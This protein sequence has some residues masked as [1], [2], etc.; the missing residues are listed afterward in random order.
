D[1]N[2]SKGTIALQAGANSACWQAKPWAH[3][4][5]S[6]SIYNYT[7]PTFACPSGYWLKPAGSYYILDFEELYA[8]YPGGATLPYGY[9]VGAQMPSGQGSLN[10]I[11]PANKLSF[12]YTAG[13][14]ASANY[15]Q[16][17]GV[18]VSGMECVKPSNIECGKCGDGIFWGLFNICDKA[19]CLSISEG[20]CFFDGRGV[21]AHCY[22]KATVNFSL[23]D[24]VNKTII[25]GAK[26]SIKDF[27]SIT[28]AS[29]S[30]G[31]CSVELGLGGEYTASVTSVSGQNLTCLSPNCIKY[32]AVSSAPTNVELNPNKV[33]ECAD[34]DASS[35]FANGAKNYY[36]KGTVSE[37]LGNFTDKCSGKTLTEYSCLNNKAVVES[38]TCSTGCYDGACL[39]SQT[40]ETAKVVFE[41]KVV[42]E[43]GIFLQDPYNPG[44]NQ[45]AKGVVMMASGN[46]TYSCVTDYQGRCFAQLP[47]GDYTVYTDDLYFQ[48]K[49]EFGCPKAIKVLGNDTFVPLALQFKPTPSAADCQDTDFGN[50]TF[51]KG[52]VKLIKPGE[53]FPSTFI[54][55]CFSDGVNIVEGWCQY[56]L[57]GDF[58]KTQTFSCKYGCFDGA[59]KEGDRQEF[60]VLDKLSANPLG[61][62]L[63]KIFDINTPSQALGFDC[64]SKSD[65]ICSINLPP[66]TGFYV[67]A[68]KSG[69]FC[70]TDVCC[71]K[72]SAPSGNLLTLKMKPTAGTACASEGEKV[73]LNCVGQSENQCCSGLTAQSSDK[74]FAVCLK[75][76]DGICTAPENDHKCP[77]DCQVP[78]SDCR[79][80]DKFGNRSSCKTEEDCAAFG[81]YCALQEGKC[82]EKNPSEVQQATLVF[83]VY[84]ESAGQIN[85]K[86]IKGATIVSNSG[87]P[88]E[89]TCST[90]DNGS[91]KIAV[92]VGKRHTISVSAFGFEPSEPFLIDPSKAIDYPLTIYLKKALSDEEKLLT[93]KYKVIDSLA[94]RQ[95]ENSD[96]F[97]PLGAV[98]GD[99]LLADGSL[100][101]TCSSNSAGLCLLSMEIGQTY[102]V[103]FSK[104]GF[105]DYAVG[106]SPTLQD[107]NY[108]VNGIIEPARIVSLVKT[109]QPPKE[110]CS[111]TDGGKNYYVPGV[112][113]GIASVGGSA[114]WADSCLNNQTISEGFCRE[115]VAGVEPSYEVVKCP[116]GCQDNACK[117]EAQFFVTGNDGITKQALAGGAQVNLTLSADPNTVLVS[118]KTDGAGICKIPLVFGKEYIA[119]TQPAGFRRY[120]KQF[121]AQTLFS[122]TGN[123]P[124]GQIIY[125]EPMTQTAPDCSACG[126]WCTSN[127]CLSLGSNCVFDNFFVG[128]GSCHSKGDQKEAQ[129]EANAQRGGSLTQSVATGFDVA[130]DIPPGALDEE[131]KL[132]ITNITDE[133]GAPP[134]GKVLVGNIVYDIR[135]IS[136]STGKEVHNFKKPITISITLNDAFLSSFDRNSLTIRYFDERTGT[137]VELP[138]TI[139]G[140][141]LLAQTTHLSLFGLIGEVHAGD[142]TGTLICPSGATD[143]DGYDPFF[144]NITSRNGATAPDSCTG[145]TLRE[146]G[147]VAP[148]N[149]PNY[150][151]ATPVGTGGIV[152][153]G[154]YLMHFQ[155]F[156]CTQKCEGVYPNPGKCKGGGTTPATTKIECFESDNG[157]MP[158]SKGNIYSQYKTDSGQILDSLSSNDACSGDILTEWSCTSPPSSLFVIESK[159]VKTNDEQKILGWRT[160]YKCPGGVGCATDE[161]RCCDGQTDITAGT[162]GCKPVE[163]SICTD[164]EPASDPDCQFVS[165]DTSVA[166]YKWI[167]QSWHENQPCGGASSGKTCQNG[168]CKGASGG[169][170]GT[171][172]TGGDTGTVPVATGTVEAKPIDFGGI[173]IKPPSDLCSGIEKKLKEGSCAGK[174]STAM[175]NC[176]AAGSE[177]RK[178]TALENC[179][180]AD[181]E[182]NQCITHPEKALMQR[183]LAWLAW[184]AFTI[185]GVIILIGAFMVMTSSGDQNK[186][187]SGKKM[188]IWAAI[189][190]AVLLA[191]R[192]I[193]GILEAVLQVNII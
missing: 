75:C 45:V 169:T 80:I 93:Y 21:G 149:I 101:D 159:P 177:S 91:C 138:T 135:A 170:G 44:Q 168:E 39:K 19:E 57:S 74:N 114:I 151:D 160:T 54:D 152:G 22:N 48:C 183:A 137:M 136:L 167:V 18:I 76:G 165:C 141:T 90:I 180:M 193:I 5:G 87:A 27:D 110:K 31:A 184:V 119:W 153:S 16:D 132:V 164:P 118:C 179:L 104:E 189:G 25:S 52:A 121:V 42:D 100:V 56:G 84:D 47:L 66:A 147:C 34:S 108:I 107:R 62:A 32:F 64:S 59:C 154:I 43:N 60:K 171:G 157:F 33:I 127:E 14:Q 97:I 192:L 3:Y 166:P 128:L 88:N 10:A 120:S 20:S 29:N 53:Q 30:Q 111:D 122:Q 15:S 63:I 81:A 146:Y 99:A 174:D 2:Q 13:G 67:S 190:L 124:L 161:G 173:K 117:F 133:T 142:A 106:Y 126:T 17:L 51:V 187:R 7:S 86:P 158:N 186:V 95:A 181:A 78:C 49:A 182:Y 28:C 155:D 6:D 46:S 131:V 185:A 139:S 148:Q 71:Q 37:T 82:V 23:K 85:K 175:V 134:K 4:L 143:S 102:Q 113:S 144:P 1:C 92:D 123:T 176:L 65:G 115:S 145:N 103:K 156:D 11:F 36:Q 50:D 162:K 68:T 89:R 9:G 12:K 188:I 116:Y 55:Y 26:V 24:A 73:Y 69:Y 172:G 112:A 129:D 140:N 38:Y 94:S 105:S 191:S 96:D 83:W 98:K 178:C 8:I 40:G 79:V 150:P 41:T 109:Q 61:S 130:V 70:E 163:S 72:V 35:Q 58:I 77:S 125:L